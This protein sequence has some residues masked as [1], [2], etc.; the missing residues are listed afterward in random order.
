MERI[1]KILTSGVFVR[2]TNDVYKGVLSV[3]LAFVL[4]EIGPSVWLHDTNGYL[5]LSRRRGY[6]QS[7]SG[8]VMIRRL[9]VDEPYLR[10]K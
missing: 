7:Q 1:N 3:V 8:E 10:R 4:I 2:L 9:Q 5:L 6:R